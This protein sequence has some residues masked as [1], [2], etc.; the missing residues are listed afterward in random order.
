MKPNASILAIT[1]LVLAGCGGGGD[2]NPP[3]DPGKRTVREVPGY[4]VSVTTADAVVAGSPVRVRVGV[5]PLDGAPAPAAIRAWVATDFDASPIAVD[6]AAVA[7]A[8]N[9][10][11][12][13]VEVPAAISADT[14]AWVQVI[15]QDGS[16]LEA[17]YDSFRLQDL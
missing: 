6:A 1:A 12:A 9:Q 4:R 3:S 11:E 7:G 10:Y 2:G 15:L 16:R 14:A 17:G 5:E 8:A 13:V